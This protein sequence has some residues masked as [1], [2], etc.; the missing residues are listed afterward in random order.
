M[1]SPQ[2]I[3]QI[4]QSKTF[5]KQQPP[6][7]QS[8]KE[9]KQLPYSSKLYKSELTIHQQTINEYEFEIYNNIINLMELNKPNMKLYNQQPY[10]TYNIRLKLIDFILKMSQRLKILPFVY[11]KAIKLFDRY[12][13]KRIILLDQ[14][15]L[16]ITTCLWISSKLIGGNNHFINLNNNNNTCNSNNGKNFKILNDLGYGSGGKYLG[17]TERFR[18][19][20]LFELIK[21]CGN[22][23]NYDF[24]MFKQMELHILNTLD[25]NLNDPS[26]EE[27]LIKSE[28]FNILPTPTIN[29][30]NNNDD[31]NNN[32]NNNEYLI[33]TYEIFK[34]KEYLSYISLY[35]NELI[36]VNI[37]ELSQVIIDLINELYNNSNSINQINSKIN[38]KMDLK[39]YKF[40]K[41]NLIK[42]IL[43]SSDFILKF[44]DSKGPQFIYK[45]IKYQYHIEISSINSDDNNNNNNNDHIPTSTTSST[46][47]IYSSRSS[48]YS[49]VI[50]SSNYTTTSLTNMD[51][52]STTTTI[53]PFIVSQLPQQNK[54]LKKFPISIDTN[55]KSLHPQQQQQTPQNFNSVQSQLN[56]NYINQIN[57]L[58]TSSLIN[59]S[60]YDI[61]STK[62]SSQSSIYSINNNNHQQ[63]NKNDDNNNNNTPLS[64]NQSPFYNLNKKLNLLF[65]DNNN[66]NNK[67]GSSNNFINVGT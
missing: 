45:Q 57:N 58:S 20:K 10:L 42:S 25:W 62:S 31:N 52:I 3:S 63:I 53:T 5:I 47:S 15:Q 7:P 64:E 4:H 2:S 32:I 49:S 65:D 46:E 11:F 38:I 60:P 50:S 48:S 67:F 36:D 6:L 26:I 40:I 28:E 24:N 22:K 44:F 61:K 37:I 59:N 41:K 30:N 29:N 39:N 12:C 35:S 51:I 33:S 17:P 43:K 55:Y 23:C 21:L 9:F 1:L 56:N 19:P 16:I 27:F 8:K 14:S 54:K 34:I 13:S 66:V 18:L